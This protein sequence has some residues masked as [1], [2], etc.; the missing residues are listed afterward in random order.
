MGKF[1]YFLSSETTSCPCPVAEE[2]LF[3]PGN[4]KMKLITTNIGRH[5]KRDDAELLAPLLEN[6]AETSH[7]YIKTTNIPKVALHKKHSP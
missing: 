2:A 3:E 4:L 1:I 7:S 5:G 6:Q